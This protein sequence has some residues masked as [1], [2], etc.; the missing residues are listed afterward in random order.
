VNAVFYPVFSITNGVK[1]SYQISSVDSSGNESPKTSII[2]D[3]QLITATMNL[4]AKSNSMLQKIYPNP[5]SDE[6]T[7]EYSVVQLGNVKFEIFN[8]AGQKVADVMLPN[9]SSGIN[10]FTWSGKLNSGIPVSAGIFFCRI[11]SNKKSEVVQ[12]VKNK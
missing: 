8:I 7:F 2:A 11:T 10:S 6:I 3:T 12:L 4:A 9:Q 5:F 1:Y